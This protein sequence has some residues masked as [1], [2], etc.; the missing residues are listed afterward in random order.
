MATQQLGNQTYTVRK[1]VLRRHEAAWVLRISASEVTSMLRRG[2]RLAAKGLS[3]T[4]IIAAGALPVSMA[5]RAKG[6]SPSLLAAHHRVTESP[7]ALAA[8][9]GL[10]EARINAPRAC[11]ATQLPPDLT[12]RLDLI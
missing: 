7:L 4:E 12:T 8:L 2:Q 1:L 6:V 3:E 9:G 5:G 10:V 11:T